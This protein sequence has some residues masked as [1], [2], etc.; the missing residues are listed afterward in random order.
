MRLN[1]EV[2]HLGTSAQ[3]DARKALDPTLDD[4]DYYVGSKWLSHPERI[5][6][7]ILATGEQLTDVLKC[8]Q[9]ILYHAPNVEVLIIVNVDN[10]YDEEPASVIIGCLQDR[11][12]PP[13]KLKSIQFLSGNAVESSEDFIIAM[14][15]PAVEWELPARPMNYVS[16]CALS[17]LRVLALPDDAGQDNDDNSVRHYTDVLSFTTE[18]CDDCQRH[19]RLDSI[20]CCPYDE[21]KRVCQLETLIV[22]MNTMRTTEERLSLIDEALRCGVSNVIFRGAL[23]P[24]RRELRAALTG[25]STA[26]SVMTDE[27]RKIESYE[28]IAKDVFDDEKFP[29]LVGLS[30]A[31]AQ[32]SPTMCM[33]YPY[34]LGG[35]AYTPKYEV[36]TYKN[37]RAQLDGTEMKPEH[38]ELLIKR[39]E[40]W[41]SGILLALTAVAIKAATANARHVL[42]N[43]LVTKRGGVLQAIA[44]FAFEIREEQLLPCTPVPW[45][46]R[47]HTVVEEAWFARDMPDI[48][49]IGRFVNDSLYIKNELSL[50]RAP[51]QV[52]PR[53]LRRSNRK[54][55]A[56]VY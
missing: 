49:W 10:Q 21:C 28:S 39:D 32:P 3:R 35:L 8:T 19:G 9:Y 17:N 22:Q 14:M 2:F 6:S 1:P 48:D 33:A 23:G 26:M 46:I 44:R 25:P 41:Q 51:M 52:E 27:Q 20:L 34:V 5:K 29:R 38:D 54:R 55:K 11:R 40:P 47:P 53:V 16:H 12:M 42:A 15:D 4:N 36:I 31:R 13:L 50:R 43:S 7:V 37:G 18:F 30:I 24:E 45:S 56:V